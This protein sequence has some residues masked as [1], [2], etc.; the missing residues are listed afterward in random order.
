[1]YVV[2]DTETNGLPKNYKA[3]PKE[4]NNWPRII[5]L[6][7]LICDEDFNIIRKCCHLIKPDGWVIPKEKFWIENGYSTEKSLAEGIPIID[8][9]QELASDLRVATHAVAHNMDFDYPIIAAEMIRAGVVVGNK[10]KKICT[11]KASVKF[12][13]IPSAR[14]GYKWP[15]LTELHQKI[16]NKGFDGA[17]DAMNDVI[18]CYLCLYQLKNY[19]VIDFS[20]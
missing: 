10:T 2:F 7:W 13:A 14:G 4:I 17:H 16:Y 18:A 15:T 5:Q 8:A 11:M 9:L 6:A 12:C 20:L 3:P 19:R 1:M